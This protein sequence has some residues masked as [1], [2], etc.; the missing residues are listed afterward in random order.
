MQKVILFKKEAVYKTDAAPTTGANAALTRNWSAEPLVVDTLDRNL[1]LPARGRVRSEHTNRRTTFGF[2]LEL[3]GSGAAGTAAPW[4][5]FLEAAGMAAP[6]VVA[7]ISATQ[8]FAAENAALSSATCH[9]WMSDQRVRA[10]GSRGTFGFDFTA[11]RYPFIK[12]DFTGVLPPP[13]AVDGTAPVGAPDFTRWKDPLEVATE[14]TSFTLDG[15]ALVLKSFSVD[16]NAD[17]KLRNL[18]GANYVNV[19]NRAMTGRIVGEAPAIG[20]KN[21]FS[22]LDTG[23]EVAV[24]LIHGVGAG[25]VVQVDGNYLEILKIT[26]AE[27]DDKLMLDISFGLNIR[28]GAD[29]LVLTAK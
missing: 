2:E 15:F 11:G 22:T 20:A 24:Q 13:P 10:L 19:G 12:F 1:D 6:A 21:Y 3:A 8:R 16:A 9:H 4:M 23:A 14:N 5:E 18:V 29:D 7:G 17:V 25:K 26:R 28:A 27:E